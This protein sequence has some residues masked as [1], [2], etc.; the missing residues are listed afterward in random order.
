[1]IIR[2]RRLRTALAALAVVLPGGLRRVVHTRLL[3]YELHP[4]ATIGRSM[5]DVDQLVMGERARIGHLVLIRG[6]EEVRLG[7]GALIH[8]LVWINSVRAEKGYFRDQPR[9]PA[10]LMGAETL[11][12]ALHFIDACDLVQLDDFSALAG[13]G[14]IVQTHAVDIDRMRQS[15]AP[16]RIGHHAMVASRAVLLPGAEVPDRSV[17]AAGAVVSRKLEGHHVFAGVPAKAVRDLD[18]EAAFFVRDT[19]QIW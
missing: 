8:M 2:T 19:S 11:I 14:S 9:R 3:G 13:V 4:T 18:P 16:I 6:C 15:S 5:V 12:S 10:L 17:V 1:M 7:P